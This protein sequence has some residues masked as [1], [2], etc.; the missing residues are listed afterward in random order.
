MRRIEWFSANE[1]NVGD[2]LYAR[3]SV[4]LLKRTI[5]QLSWPDVEDLMLATL[6]VRRYIVLIN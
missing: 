4:Y 6:K 1:G 5:V 2:V 3:G